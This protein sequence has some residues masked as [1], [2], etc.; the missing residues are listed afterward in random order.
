MPLT[1][2]AGDQVTLVLGSQL[3]CSINIVGASNL[4]GWII[5]SVSQGGTS[6]YNSNLSMGPTLTITVGSTPA[7][8]YTSNSGGRVTTIGSLSSGGGSS[9]SSSSSSSAPAPVVQEFGKPLSG[10]CADA[11]PATLNWG[12]ASSGGW[13]ESWAQW[14]NGG[15]GGA[16]CTRSLVYSTSSGRWGVS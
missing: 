15:R 9:S 13:S 16:V 11:A 6:S 7:D 1:L 3:L 4:T 8:I 14:M 12:G 10:T 5:N 2:Q